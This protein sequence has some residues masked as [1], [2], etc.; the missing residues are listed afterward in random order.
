MKTTKL[1][2]ACSLFLF[3][4]TSINANSL[5]D[6]KNKISKTDL[7]FTETK[8][9]PII[10]NELSRKAK[11]IE[12]NNE[13]LYW[14]D[15]N[16][17]TKKEN[18]YLRILPPAGLQVKKVPN[19]YERIIRNGQVVYFA[20]GIFYSKNLS[21]KGFVIVEG[22]IGVQISKLPESS[23]KAKFNNR[24]CYVYY[25]TV[26]KK[27]SSRSRELYSLIGYIED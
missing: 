16:Y 5:G 7:T 14:L 12:F 18:K 9:E 4:F 15:D 10:L 23:T 22:P 24:D 8:P 3:A 11:T 2:L 6:E 26:Y 20:N 13:E 21:K 27:N 19:N 17:Y 25:N 1:I